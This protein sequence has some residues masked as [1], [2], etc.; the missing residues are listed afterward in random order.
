M[1]A[2][3]L[4]RVCLFIRARLWELA[5]LLPLIRR[6]YTR[7]TF[8]TFTSIDKKYT[9]ASSEQKKKELMKF[10]QNARGD[11]TG[12]IGFT[13]PSHV[14]VGVNLESAARV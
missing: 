2:A 7:N 4:E 1:N 5:Y 10:T 8:S 3:A 6:T 11:H 9:R 13:Y 12:S 14:R